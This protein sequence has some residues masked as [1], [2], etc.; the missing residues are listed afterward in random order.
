[1]GS[2]ARTYPTIAFWAHSKLGI[3]LWVLIY[4]SYLFKLDGLYIQLKEVF[5]TL[6]PEITFSLPFVSE[7]DSY[8]PFTLFACFTLRSLYSVSSGCLFQNVL[9]V[10]FQ[11]ETRVAEP[12]NLNTVPVPTFYL[13]TAPVPVPVPGHIHAYMYTYMYEYV[14]GYV[15]VYVYVFVNGYVYIYLNIYFYS[16]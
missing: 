2:T 5:Y 9:D 11:C 4:S 16:T 3:F 6:F 7:S 1:M 14:Y 8:F 10:R 13:N 15:Y 12:E